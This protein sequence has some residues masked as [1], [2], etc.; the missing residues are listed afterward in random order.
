ME[1]QHVQELG[2]NKQSVAQ[3]VG[4]DTEPAVVGDEHDGHN[5]VHDVI[6]GVV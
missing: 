3:A 6:L 1:P 4:V 2:V 5:A